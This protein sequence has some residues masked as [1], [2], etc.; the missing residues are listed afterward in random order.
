MRT[1]L[2]VTA[3][4]AAALASRSTAVVPATPLRAAGLRDVRELVR[5]EPA[6]ALRSP[7]RTGSCRRRRAEPTV[8]ARA[9]NRFARRGRVGAV[10]RCARAERS[11]PSLGSKYARSFRSSGWPARRAGH[12]LAVAVLHRVREL[13]REQ[14][15]ARAT[16]VGE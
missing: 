10:V 15:P 9:R 5:D 14:P 7:A 6:A 2:P 12:L 1:G 13:V 8:Y 11:T 16:L 4:V 3:A